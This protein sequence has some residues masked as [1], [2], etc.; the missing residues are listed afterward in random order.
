MRICGPLL[1]GA[2]A[3]HP[4]CSTSCVDRS[5][6]IDAETLK[7]VRVAGHLEVFA[8]RPG[9]KL[10]ISACPTLLFLIIHCIIA[11]MLEK[12]A[13]AVTILFASSRNHRNHC[14]HPQLHSPP[15]AQSPSL[16]SC[17]NSISLKLAIASRVLPCSTSVSQP[18]PSRGA[19]QSRPRPAQCR[20]ASPHAS[21]Q[22]CV[23]AR[24]TGS[25]SSA[26]PLFSLRL[27]HVES[28]SA[29]PGGLPI[30]IEKW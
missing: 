27:S 3:C 1:N 28:S 23:G 29:E 12:D 20:Q 25:T 14:I 24:Q 18:I 26:V 9:G 17:K 2:F 30:V 21:E 6:C 7:R 5:R 10:L 11:F 22:P 13:L 16:S 19:R 8:H 4:G 15:K